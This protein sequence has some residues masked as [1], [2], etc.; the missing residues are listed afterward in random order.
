[1]ICTPATQEGRNWR[2][3]AQRPSAAQSSSQ[4]LQQKMESFAQQ[5]ARDS[6]RAKTLDAKIGHLN[7]LLQDREA[8]D[9][10]DE[11]LAH[12]RDIRDLMGARDR[13]PW[14]ATSGDDFV[15]AAETA[16]PF[17]RISRNPLEMGGHGA[18]AARSPKSVA[19]FASTLARMASDLI[20]PSG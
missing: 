19:R 12:D 13:S 10:K 11:P 3:N 2:S 7:R 6:A 8:L 15:R 18:V 1:M 20:R 5:S 4:E 16:L 14:V 9:Q 17:F